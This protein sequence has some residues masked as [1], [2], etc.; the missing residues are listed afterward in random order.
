MNIFTDRGR[1]LLAAATL[2]LAGFARPSV[3]QTIKEFPL[4]NAGSNPYEVA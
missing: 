4:S 2:A 1:L 3:A